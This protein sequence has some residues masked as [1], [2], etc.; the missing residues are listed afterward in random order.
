MKRTIIAIAAFVTLTACTDNNRARNW[1]GTEDLE[2]P[3]DRK[4]VNVT[5]KENQ[6]W[7]V[8][9]DR[10]AADSTYDTYRFQEKSSWGVLEGTIVIT[11]KQK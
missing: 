4:F 7:I 2:V 9:K 8:T 10:T 3:A 1:G 11:E 5:W 6:L